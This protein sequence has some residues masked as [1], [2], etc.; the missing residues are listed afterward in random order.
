MVKIFSLTV[1]FVVCLASAALAQ[2]GPIN[3]SHV[4]ARASNVS[5]AAVYM[6]IANSAAP[7]IGWCRPIAGRENRAALY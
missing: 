2:S 4:W 6:T 7:T 5:T 3:V 1:A